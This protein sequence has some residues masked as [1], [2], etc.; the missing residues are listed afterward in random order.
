VA[1]LS[2][3]TLGPADI[4]RAVPLL[5]A[6][7]GENP[8]F[9]ARLRRYLAAEPEGWVVLDGEGGLAGM[10]GFVGF[11]P[12]AYIGLMAVAPTEQRRGIG[13]AVFEELLHR[14]AARGHEQ[15][16][17]DAS[18]VGAPLY[19]KYGFHDHG[20][21]AAW[22]LDARAEGDLCEALDDV[23]VDHLTERDVAEVVAL[24]AA[25]FGADRS[26][27]VRPVLAAATKRAFVA[28]ERAGSVVGY[29]VGQAR[30]FGPCLARSPRVADALARRALALPYDGKVM[31]LVAEQ[32]AGAIALARSL[33]ATRTRAWRHM[34][35]G[36]NALLTSDWSTLFAKVSLAAG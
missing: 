18:A 29:A 17:L 26:A 15:L 3:R 19:A 33:G 7:Y 9:E 6:A 20:E 31:W 30:T 16:L 5:N 23:A 11:G 13:A 25:C 34:R 10:G 8:M 2:L 14:C 35:R 24:D 22:S 1:T 21:A 12:C 4:A 36:P 27:L 32:N 28:R